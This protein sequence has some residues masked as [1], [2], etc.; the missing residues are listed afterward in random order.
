MSEYTNFRT[1]DFYSSFCGEPLGIEGS[2]ARYKC[3]RSTANKRDFYVSDSGQWHCKHAKCASTTACPITG[4][5]PRQFLT[6][7]APE[8]NDK[9]AFKKLDSFGR[10]STTK[11]TKK[12]KKPQ[13]TKKIWKSL[14]DIQKW[15]KA[16]PP[17][18]K[19]FKN[20]IVHE[21]PKADGSPCLVV[22][23]CETGKKK[24]K[25]FRQYHIDSKGWIAG[26]IKEK[27]PLYRLSEVDNKISLPVIVCEGEKKADLLQKAL[28]EL[29]Y[30]VTSPPQGS[31]S[32]QKADWA[33]VKGRQVFI[34]P[35]NDKPGKTF[36][37]KVSALCLKAGADSTAVIA[38]F[39]GKDAG[40]SRDI[41]DFLSEGGDLETINKAIKKATP[42]EREPLK[43]TFAASSGANIYD[44]EF[45]PIKW[46]V[47]GILAEGFALL[48]G[49]PKRGKSWFA[50][51][52]SL[53]VANG[54][55]ALGKVK[56][57]P[58]EVLYFALEDNQRRI[59]S[60]LH[61]LMS[62]DT[63]KPKNVHFVTDVPRFPKNQ[64]KEFR[65]WFLESLN[66]WLEEHP[67]TRLIVIDTISHPSITPP[68]AKGADVS[69]Q[70][71][72]IA[73]WFQKI[74]F[75]KDICILGLRH[76]R[77]SSSGDPIDD[78][79]GST[80]ITAAI[81]TGLVISSSEESKTSAT[82]HITGR[83]VPRQDLAMNFS[84]CKWIIMGNA[85]DF[86]ATDQ[87]RPIIELLRN[88]GALYPAEIT[89]KLN[90][91]S[92]TVRSILQR[93]KQTGLVVQ[94]SGPRSKYALPANLQANLSIP[95]LADGGEVI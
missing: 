22:F 95:A 42:G 2:Q 23:R 76:T 86:N 58:G 93:M 74:S 94:E 31:Q 34:F 63:P 60:R 35:D 17:R 12:A 77:K 82:L 64:D 48:G 59:Q 32:P 24:E 68:K 67:E 11:P 51:A 54:G 66:N 8:L 40:D 52:L 46:I 79:A 89:K 7:A 75:S 45:P 72:E 92:S 29:S 39:Y 61:K 33:P 56:V 57:D 20:V 69:G 9:E 47:P 44:K 21:Y 70:D 26:A 14:E 18:G 5:G 13:I 87:Q 36:A 37:D 30:W 38:P 27:R 19:G 85:E 62:D 65:I 15:L 55:H 84:N 49:R 10:N 80:G 16:K 88:C 73:A 50:L 41:A 81:D 1:D 6:M 25:E 3:P 43:N 71:Y 90:M 91:P 53:A 28:P 4:G 78:F 83:D